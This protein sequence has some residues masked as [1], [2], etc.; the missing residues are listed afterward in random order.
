MVRRAQSLLC[1]VYRRKDAGREK[2]KDSGSQS[3][4]I[5]H[6]HENRLVEHVGVDLVEKRILPWNS[7]AIDDARDG[8]AVRLH[9]LEDDAGMKRSAF[10]GRE[11]L[12]FRT[13]HQVP[14]ERYATQLRIDLD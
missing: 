13:V 2:C 11:Q 14:A 10:D 3:R 9:V 12:V 4:D 6:R 8:S 1:R 5:S 7:A